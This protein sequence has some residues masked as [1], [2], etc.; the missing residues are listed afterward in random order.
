MR[1]DAGFRT[2]AWALREVKLLVA[3]ELSLQP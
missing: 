2:V 1:L 3:T